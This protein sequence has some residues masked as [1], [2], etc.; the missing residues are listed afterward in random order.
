MIAKADDETNRW[1]G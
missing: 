1:A